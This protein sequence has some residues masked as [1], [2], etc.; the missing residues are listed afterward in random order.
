M[1][2]I[3]AFYIRL[4]TDNITAKN[5]I[6]QKHYGLCESPELEIVTENW[7]N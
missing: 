6:F 1:L 3:L 4:L 2:H 5:F 7:L